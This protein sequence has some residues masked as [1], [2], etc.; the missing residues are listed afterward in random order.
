MI[1][2][3]KIDGP[4]SFDYSRLRCRPEEDKLKEKLK[5]IQKGEESRRLQA[6]QQYEKS[7]NNNFG[8]SKDELKK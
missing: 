6:Q 7:L 3:D 8:K 5:Y 1:K 4:E 2:F